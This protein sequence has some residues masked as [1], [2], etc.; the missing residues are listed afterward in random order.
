MMRSNT[1]TTCLL[2]DG[3]AEEAVNFYRSIFKDSKILKTMV[4]CE[5]GPGPKGSVMAIVFELM[6]QE[7]IALNGP[8][9][10]PSPAI[11]FLVACET[12]QEIDAYWEKLLAGGEEIQCG[13]LT[14]RYGITWQIVPAAMADMMQ[15]KDPEKS[16]R[17]MEAM[18]KMKK[19]DLAIL[20]RAYEGR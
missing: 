1:I 4:H 6:G 17:V 18:F 19:L 16:R 5:A 20:R 3:K 11:S 15:D 14:D 8:R 9:F 2:F 12:Q 13:W 7:F 10:A